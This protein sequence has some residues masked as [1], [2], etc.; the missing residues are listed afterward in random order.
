M[1]MS[2]S[3]LLIFGNNGKDSIWLY[4]NFELFSEEYIL[5]LTL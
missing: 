2:S 4:S 1:T 3:R 5:Q